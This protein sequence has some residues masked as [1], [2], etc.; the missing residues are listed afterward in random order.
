M[1][2]WR[3]REGSVPLCRLRVIIDVKGAL[4]HYEAGA[5][6]RQISKR[7]KFRGR[8]EIH[9]C[10]PDRLSIIEVNRGPWIDCSYSALPIEASVPDLLPLCTPLH[11]FRGEH[12]S[13]HSSSPHASTHIAHRTGLT[14]LG[15]ANKSM[16]PGVVAG[17]HRCRAH[18]CPIA[19]RSSARVTSI[20]PASVLLS[21]APRVSALCPNRTQHAPS[22]LR[23]G[24]PSPP[25]GHPG[26]AAWPVPS[27]LFFRL[28]L[29]YRHFLSR[30]VD[31]VEASK[32]YL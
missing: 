18:S 21:V 9:A 1:R 31:E 26:L 7:D 13:D 10:R 22:T 14:A 6:P 8:F 32:Y 4:G 25:H 17:P 20:M 23:A 27:S 15:Q 12:S 24:A 28:R 5:D 29:L 3:W 2:D 19:A 16:S 11:R 30:H